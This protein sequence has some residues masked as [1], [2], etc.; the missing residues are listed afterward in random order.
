M[1]NTHC[2]QRASFWLQY[3]LTMPVLVLMYDSILQ[4]RVTEYLWTR[5]LLST[6]IAIVAAACDMLC[7]FYNQLPARA[8][9]RDTDADNPSIK[10]HVAIH[11]AMWWCWGCWVVG[12]SA[13]MYTSPPLSV[14][15]PDM[16]LV[17]GAST[18]IPMAFALYVV[19]LPMA[20]IPGLDRSI[21]HP[22]E[23][24]DPK[25]EERDANA[26]G[27]RLVLEMSTRLLVTMTVYF[28]LAQ[29]ALDMPSWRL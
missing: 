7:I 29:P 27:I 1:Q 26:L 4:Q 23:D 15:W 21:S 10:A 19:V 18:T 2:V 13:L 22:T 16:T 12:V 8:P 5:L 6:G 9:T 17:S 14:V 24:N 20:C 3:V 25:T 11:D 28:W